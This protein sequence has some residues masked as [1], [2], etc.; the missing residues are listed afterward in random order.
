MASD[1]HFRSTVCAHAINEYQLRLDVQPFLWPVYYITSVIQDIF[2]ANLR[3]HKI[4]AMRM[5]IIPRGII[6]A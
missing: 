3:L 4:F 5:C 1:M 2:G 6:D